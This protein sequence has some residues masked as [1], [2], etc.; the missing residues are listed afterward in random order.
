MGRYFRK[1]E[2]PT[3]YIAHS[4]FKMF[5]LSMSILNCIL[6]IIAT[7]GKKT[8]IVILNR[9]R[10]KIC[11]FDASVPNLYFPIIYAN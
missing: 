1:A 9:G 6:L 4:E 7:L 5:I 11:H 3:N 10:H 8:F 2:R